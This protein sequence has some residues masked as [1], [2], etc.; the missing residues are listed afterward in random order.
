M[1][2]KFISEK[3]VDYFMKLLCCNIKKFGHKKMFMYEVGFALV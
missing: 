1:I 3:N 2:K